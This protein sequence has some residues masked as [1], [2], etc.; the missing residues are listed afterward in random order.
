MK[1]FFDKV[2]EWLIHKLGG[3]TMAELLTN[4][5]PIFREFPIESLTV[6]CNV[7]F[8][9][10]PITKTTAIEMGKR[11]ICQRLAQGLIDNNMVNMEYTEDVIKMAYVFRGTIWAA[12]KGNAE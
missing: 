9:L 10:L 6:E 8:N 1:R 2:K 12:K 7:P 11:E 4:E 3:W 5:V